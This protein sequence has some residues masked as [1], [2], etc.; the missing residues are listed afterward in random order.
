[1]GSIPLR[2]LRVKKFVFHPIYFLGQNQETK[3]KPLLSIFSP[4]SAMC[5]PYTT[6][7]SENLPLAFH[8]VGGREIEGGFEIEGIRG[9]HI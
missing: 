9:E 6:K 1:M 5:L 4:S 2:T 7:Y 8:F 3:N